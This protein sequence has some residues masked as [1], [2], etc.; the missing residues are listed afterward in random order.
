MGG[1][2]ARVGSGGAE[3]VPWWQHKRQE[4]DMGRQSAFRGTY[5]NSPPRDC[6][7]NPDGEC[8]LCQ[9]FCVR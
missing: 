6:E 2:L 4:R 3:G 1:S 8:V 7:R 5:L 9:F